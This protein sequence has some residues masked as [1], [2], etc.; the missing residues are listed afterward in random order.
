VKTSYPPFF[1]LNFLAD[2]IKLS[3]NQKIPTDFYGP[4]YFPHFGEE[5]DP[6]SGTWKRLGVHNR[7]KSS[8]WAVSA[9]DD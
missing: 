9:A 7:Q 4:K 6:G 8:G 3:R 5:N 2:D 1:R